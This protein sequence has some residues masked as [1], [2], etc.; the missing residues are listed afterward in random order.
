MRFKRLTLN[1]YI[2]T[3]LGIEYVDDIRK[4][5]KSSNTICGITIADLTEC[6]YQDV[7]H[8]I[9]SLIDSNDYEEVILRVLQTTKKKITLRMVFAAKPHDR[10]LF[11]FWIQEQYKQIN[12]LE[13]RLL[14]SSPAPEQINAGIHTLNV[15]G[16]VNIIDVIAGGDITK[17]AE[18]RNMPYGRIFEKQYRGVLMDAITQKM[19]S[20]RKN[21]RK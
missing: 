6:S 17:W 11:L 7:K 8:V 2:L 10:L 18:I 15:L 14:T 21:K 19:E 16:D 9:P 1:E 5:V 4:Y 3:K 20:N 12:T 13:E